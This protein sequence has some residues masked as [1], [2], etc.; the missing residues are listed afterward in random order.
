MGLLDKLSEGLNKGIGET[1]KLLE[2][3]K[4][5]SRVSTLGKERTDLFT[6]LGKYIYDLHRREPVT[7]EGAADLCERI[8][9]LE[10][11]VGRLESQIESLAGAQ[12]AD[13]VV[14]SACGA[15][16]ALGAAFCAGCGVRI[17]PAQETRCEHCSVVL[18]PGAAFCPRCGTSAPTPETGTEVE[19]SEAVSDDQ[20]GIA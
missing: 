3:G 12:G 14:C 17:V 10:L 2:L 20:E 1:E 19:S 18:Q 5:R 4:L 8:R 6:A 15:S 7:I 13:V 16:N 11:E 9:Q